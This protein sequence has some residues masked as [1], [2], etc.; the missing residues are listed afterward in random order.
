M[1]PIQRGFSKLACLQFSIFMS[2]PG[3]K[4]CS[5]FD[6]PLQGAAPTSANDT[7]GYHVSLGSNRWP[8]MD[9]E[10]VAEAWYRTRMC[11]TL[12]D[13][14]GGEEISI[15][16]HEFRSD[17]AVFM[18]NLSK[19]LEDPLLGHSGVTTMNSS[20]LVLHFKGMPAAVQVEGVDQ[21]RTLFVS[22]RYD[23]TVQIG[24]EG[25]SVYS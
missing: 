17:S 14:D 16:P 19:T 18:L 1:L 20:N 25:C 6:H 2:R 23:S 22:C 24:Q 7:F 5:T 12:L 9:V 15:T 8:T 4:E 11:L 3:T 10:G 21:P 13:K